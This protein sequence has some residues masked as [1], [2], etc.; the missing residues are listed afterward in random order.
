[1]LNPTNRAAL[2]LAALATTNALGQTTVTTDVNVPAGGTLIV[3]DNTTYLGTVTLGA[4]SQVVVDTGFEM[5]FADGASL[6]VEGTESQPVMFFPI[7]GTWE[8]LKFEAGSS[9]DI[10]YAA[11]MDFRV[12]GVEANDAEVS[13]SGVEIFDSTSAPSPVS[14]TRYGVIARLG[15]TMSID[16]SLIGPITGENGGNGSTGNPGST[17]GSGDAVTGIDAR[18]VDLLNVTS[19][20]FVGLQGGT[21]GRGGNGSTGSNGS[22]GS[23]DGDNGSAGGTGRTG[24]RGGAGGATTV[25]FASGVQDIT[26][27]QNIV[28]RI[29]G[30]LGGQ[31]GTG[32]RG[33][34][35][36]NGADGNSPFIGAGGDGGNGGNGGRGGNGGTGGSSGPLQVFRVVDAGSEAIIANNTVYQANAAAGGSGGTRGSGGSGGTGGD[37]GEGSFPFSDGSDGSNGSTGSLGSNGAAGAAGAAD[38]VTT[39]GSAPSGFA[40]LVHNNIMSFIGAGP[41]RPAFSTDT[42]IIDITTNA[43]SGFTALSTGPAIGGLTVVTDAPSFVDP[44]VGDFTPLAGTFLVDAADNS[45][46]P[47]VL[48]LDFLGNPRFADELTTADT[49]TGG[50]FIVDYGAIEALG[51]SAQPSDCL[52]DVNGDGLVTPADF[53]AWIIAFNSQAPEC[54]QNGD[55]I[56]APADFNAWII[57]YNNGC[58]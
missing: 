24:G 38:A 29:S 17:G 45:L 10:D 22:N 6:V 42:G 16:Q 19:T 18:D 46:V 34:R 1:M 31:G 32:G 53:N 52:A 56:C 44:A 30:G 12:V 3:N 54:D 47:G 39:T 7:N 27:A 37:G 2:L 11:I 51:D 4:G 21:G 35:G 14:G 36:G 40:A 58:D 48:T 13:L 25:I 50:D 23:D 5:S 57:N 55:G 15:G 8:G 26:I 43:F 33:G 9:A 20:R 41:R 49:G 28:D